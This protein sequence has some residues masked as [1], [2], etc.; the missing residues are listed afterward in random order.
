MGDFNSTSQADPCHHQVSKLAPP[1]AL[2]R[3]EEAIPV[4]PILLT[5]HQLMPVERDRI[6]HPLTW[7]PW[8][9]LKF[10]PV[11]TQF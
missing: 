2:T 8:M 1:W 4:A 9:M 7:Q 11:F 6:W 5:Q 10:R 3:N